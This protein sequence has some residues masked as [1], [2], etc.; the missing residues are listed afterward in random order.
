MRVV[1]RQ[2]CLRQWR[3]ATSDVRRLALNR[4]MHA[5]L[6]AAQRR[7]LL[8][9]SAT[10]IVATR[11]SSVVLLVDGSCHDDVCVIE[12]LEHVLRQQGAARVNR[13]DCSAES[14]AQALDAARESPLIV[15]A[16]FNAH[17]TFCAQYRAKVS[18]PRRCFRNGV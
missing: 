2:T 6:R 18:T 8:P 11:D 1:S 3:S 17:A 15:D 5:A 12:D 4:A 7:E 13:V 10:S 9:S 16:C 14:G